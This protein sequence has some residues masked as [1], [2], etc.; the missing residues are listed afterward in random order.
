VLA[1]AA[2]ARAAESALASEIVASVTSV[3][4]DVIEPAVGAV[5]A[6][7]QPWG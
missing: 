5:A 2:L 3:L 4:A 6:K 7:V 1:F